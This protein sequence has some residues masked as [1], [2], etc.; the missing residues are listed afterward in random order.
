M[1]RRIWLLVVLVVL[2]TAGC[3]EGTRTIRV[4]ADGSGTIVDTLVLGDQMN[5]MMGMDAANQD[6]EAKA[7]EKAKGEAAALAMGPG[8]TLVSDERSASG[9]KTTFAFKDVSTLKV[10]VSP[11]PEGDEGPGQKKEQPL[12]FRLARQGAKSV[13]TVVQPKPPA[14]PAEAGTPPAEAGAGGEAPDLGEMG[15][16]MWTMMKPMMKGLRL[17]TVLEVDGPVAKTNSP[18]AQG[19][20]ITLLELDFDQIAADEAN[21]K[22]F[23][24]AGDDPATMDPKLLQGVKGIKVSPHAEVVIEFTGR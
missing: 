16:A 14:A 5:A 15:Q 24:K 6:A 10:G 7:K 4:K 3:F 1:R 21:F 22:K 17:K 2:V 23:T 9:I 19:S 11:G 13:L 20:A 8:V 18:F 12:T